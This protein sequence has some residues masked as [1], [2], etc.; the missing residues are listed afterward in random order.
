MNILLALFLLLSTIVISGVPIVR[1]Y[2]A[3]AKTQSVSVPSKIPAP[4]TPT[5]TAA[6][7]PKEIMTSSPV[8]ITPE[9]TVTST[10]SPTPAPASDS[11][12]DLLSVMNSY[13]QAN[14]KSVLSSNASLCRIAATRAREQAQAGSLDNHAGFQG[15]AA[16][17]T[18]FHHVGEI[19]QYQPY[20]E[21]AQ[22]LVYTG[23][24]TSGEHVAIMLDP[25]WTNGCGA[26]SGL[27]AVFIFA[28]P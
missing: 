18:E 4:V 25:R 22:Y 23:W 15:E 3:R 21:S 12:G 9:P 8:T 27:F 1:D 7:T 6:E 24:G 11:S 19:L 10:V 28:N 17:Q 16:S 5:P 2:R 13:R 20:P 14:G 26:T